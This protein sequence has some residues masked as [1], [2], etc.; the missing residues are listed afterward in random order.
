M[1]LIGS[2]LFVF[3]FMACSQDDTLP[4][5]TPV[6]DVPI[7]VLV[8]QIAKSGDKVA[9]HYTGTLDSGEVFD[10]SLKLEPLAFVLDSG[11]MILGFDDAVHGLKVGE[12][13]T[14]RLEPE[15]AYGESRDDLI[16]EFPID[17]L[18][19][20]FAEGDT[21]MF[22]NGAQGVILEIT[23]LNFKIDANHRLAGQHLTFEIELISIQ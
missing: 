4:T 14:V 11:Q 12:S 15:E 1:L 22:Q 23:K 3:T 16:I 2:A 18:P 7:P 20:G 17:E 10:S 6:M 9:V 5:S 13:V 8:H 19:K 21:I